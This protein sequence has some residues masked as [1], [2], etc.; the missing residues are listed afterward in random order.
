MSRN[1]SSDEFM[2]LTNIVVLMAA[3]M[4]CLIIYKGGS[5]AYCFNSILAQYERMVHR[6][7]S[8]DAI[9][10]RNHLMSKW[11]KKGIAIGKTVDKETP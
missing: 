10:D 4:C 9:K 6:R 11:I 2:S 8:K 3:L 7:I 1:R 5:A